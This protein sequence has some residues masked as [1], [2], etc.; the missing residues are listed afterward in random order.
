MRT[1]KQIVDTVPWELK[2][3]GRWFRLLECG[4]DVRVRL[5]KAGRVVYNADEVEA[6][7]WSMP[8]GGFDSVDVTSLAGPQLVKV[9]ISDGTAGYDRYTGTVNLALGDSVTNTG[10]VAVGIA[11]TLIVPADASRKGIRFLN[12]GA[13]VVYLGGA[14]VDLANGCLKLNGGDL[15]VEGD[16]PAAAWYAIADGGPGSLKVQEL[17]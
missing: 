6:G 5:M 4:G 3:P 10:L 15:W 1:E 13:N 17:S 16:A 9:G 14:G 7:F 8:E 2:I 12:A 11:A